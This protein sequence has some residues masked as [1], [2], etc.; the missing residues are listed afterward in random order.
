MSCD[1]NVPSARGQIKMAAEEVEADEELR[2]LVAQTLE[3]KGVLSKIKV[4]F[5]LFIIFYVMC[6][7][8]I[9]L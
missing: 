4:S 3:N 7:L 1:Q 5:I 6:L 9:A 2:E 8:A